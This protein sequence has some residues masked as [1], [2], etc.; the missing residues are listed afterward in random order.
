MSHVQRAIDSSTLTTFLGDP[1]VLA[2]ANIARAGSGRPSVHDSGAWSRYARLNV[3]AAR[4]H[5]G[6]VVAGAD[7]ACGRQQWYVKGCV[8]QHIHADALN[9][10]D[11]YQAL[12][13][14][15]HAV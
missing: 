7:V 15:V 2:K 3:L 13:L 9:V 12:E 4:H 11:A 14:G 1:R 6:V 8:G 10:R 5:A